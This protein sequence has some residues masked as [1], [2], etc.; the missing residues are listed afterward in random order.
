MDR[1]TPSQFAYSKL[2]I[3]ANDGGVVDGCNARREAMAEAIFM[4]NVNIRS[5]IRRKQETK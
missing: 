1:Q 4:V 2:L 3:N 5:N